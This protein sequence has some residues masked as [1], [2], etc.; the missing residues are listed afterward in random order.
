MTR[1]EKREA[2]RIE[3]ILLAKKNYHRASKV[4]STKN[5]EQGEWLFNW[6]GKKLSE[7]L[8]HCNYAHTATRI[9][10][11]EEIVIYDKDLGFW[12]VTEW[13]YEINLEELWSIAVRAFHG[14]S[15]SPEEERERYISKYKEWGEILFNKHS[16][17]MSVMITGPARFPSRRNEKMNN[18]DK[19]N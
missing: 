7:N 6:R 15:F 16:R 17:I 3:Q 4:I 11:N 10:D 12:Y 19:K 8:M 5:P 9:S 13:K 14:T 1:E 18:Y 2:D